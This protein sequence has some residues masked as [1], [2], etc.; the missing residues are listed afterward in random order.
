[1]SVKGTWENG[2]DKVAEVTFIIET[3]EIVT[4]LLRNVNY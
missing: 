2:K 3:W 1:M 4:V